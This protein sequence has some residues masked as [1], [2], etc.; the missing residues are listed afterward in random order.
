MTLV[1][2]AGSGKTRL[3]IEVARR[4]S[5]GQRVAAGLVELAAVSNP[6][7]L[8]HAFASALGIKESQSRPATEMLLE[9]LAG[10]NGLILVDNC[11][12][13]VDACADL[14]D[15]LLRRCPTLTIVATSREPLRVDGESVWPVPTL[16]LPRAGAST[17]QVAR[18]EAV[19]LFVERAHQVS[20]GFDLSE[21]NAGDVAAICG[22]LDGLPLAVELAASRIAQF[23]PKS[24]LEQ[25]SDRFRFLTSGLRTAPARQKTLRAAIDWSYDLLTDEERELFARMS[26]FAGEFDA[27]A[28]Q[29]VGFGGSVHGNELLDVLGRLI[30]KSLIVAVAGSADARRYRLL[31]SLRAYG[32]ERLAEAG[33]LESRK[34]L[35]AEHFTALACGGPELPESNGSLPTIPPA[36]VDN[37]REALGWSRI[38]DP[39][40]Y[41]RLA[42]A[43][44]WFGVRSGHLAEARSWLEP[45]QMSSASDEA[46]GARAS[47][48]L[49]VLAWRQGDLNAA[50]RYAA[51]AVV[52]SRAIGEPTAL[53]L[54]LG[55]LAFVRIVALRFDD[56]EIALQE[57][58]AIAEKLGDQRLLAEV[59]YH[60]GLL[61]AHRRQ[62][63]A[64][65][66]HL[67]QSLALHAAVGQ[68]DDSAVNSAFG[69]V[70][71]MLGDKERARPVIAGALR[72]RLQVGNVADLAASLDASAE[73]AHLEGFPRKAIRLK[74]AADAIYDRSGGKPP[75]MAAASRERWVRRAE[76]SIGYRALSDWQDGRGLTVKEATAYALG[77]SGQPPPRSA[78]EGEP[79]LTSREMQ[80]AELVSTGLTNEAIALRLGVSA[81]TVDSHLDHIR[82]KLGVRSRVEISNWI[83]RESAA[84]PH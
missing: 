70:L 24:I 62:L 80:I 63:G 4:S 10:F 23:T 21:S 57:E 12:H 60:V 22:R 54:A 1:G 45:A 65:R 77:S 67:E 81:R 17:R 58:V 2:A 73:L 6:A 32:L 28:A 15:R 7:M 34:R 36:D 35:H 5:H 52:L 13:L 20:P 37:L 78:A 50:E 40:L 39:S 29:A 18:A 55:S 26:V 49:G 11:E 43:F 76:R 66:D 16:S 64:A 83:A 33:E 14:V 31:E 68:A 27:S 47:A 61:E 71:L 56:A 8:P 79:K 38:A 84:S 41:L 75:S 72:L 44:G 19:Q 30:D 48:I 3:A 42:C 53:A 74:G 25:L 69:W 51:Q 59:L 9:R 46:L 82:T